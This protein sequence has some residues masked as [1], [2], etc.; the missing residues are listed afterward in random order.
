MA[1][2]P[3]AVAELALQPFTTFNPDGV[4]LISGSGVEK[5]NPMTIS[6]GMF[7]IMWGR[8]VMM[9]MVRPVRHTWEFITG[10]ADF[11]VNWMPNDWTDALRICGSQSGRDTDKVAATGITLVHGEVAT[12]PIIDQAA[13]SLEC[14]ILYRHDLDPAKFLDPTPLELY[15][16]ADYH[17]LFFGEI[18]AASGVEEFRCG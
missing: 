6:W 13:L 1:K 8:P 15:P 18:V 16:M 3:I 14:R 11:T 2:Q 4:I 7:G 12:S 9:V 17:G 5:S 10:A